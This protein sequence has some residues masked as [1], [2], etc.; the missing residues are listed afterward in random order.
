[1]TRRSTEPLIQIAECKGA[2]VKAETLYECP[3]SLVDEGA[4]AT[5]RDFLYFKTLGQPPLTGGYHDWPHAM[6]ES[7]VHL[8][9]LYEDHAS[10]QAMAEQARQIAQLKD[11]A[12]ADTG[13]TR[14]GRR[15]SK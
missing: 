3:T 14:P 11:H 12:K 9:R 7:W 4:L 2:H 8:T 1:M 13:P 6:V 5:V 10:R 15:P